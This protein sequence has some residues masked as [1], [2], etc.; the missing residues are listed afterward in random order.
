MES[1]SSVIDKRFNKSLV[2]F[3]KLVD[4]EKKY[5]IDELL[6]KTWDSLTLKDQRRL[7][8]Y[9]LYRKWR[10][11]DIF[12]EPYAIIRNCHPV[13]FNWNGQNMLNSLLRSQ[14][15]M[16][17]AKYNGSFGIYT[18]DEAKQYDMTIVKKLN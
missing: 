10:G 5:K 17:S 12:G 1:L 18:L 3:L 13:P 16:V 9:I 2:C 8:L 4:P 6:A 11:L 14:T 15:K 7:Y